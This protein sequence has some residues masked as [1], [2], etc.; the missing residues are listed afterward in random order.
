MIVDPFT[1]NETPPW[2]KTVALGFA[3]ALAAAIATKAG[4]WVVDVVRKRVEKKD[5]ASS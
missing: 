1:E 2:P 5:E 3:T 4:E